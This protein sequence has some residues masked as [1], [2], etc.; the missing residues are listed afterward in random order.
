MTKYDIADAVE[1]ELVKSKTYTWKD[2]GIRIFFES[3]I[4]MFVSFVESL[5]SEETKDSLPDVFKAVAQVGNEMML[6]E[7]FAENAILEA[8]FFDEHRIIT[9][10]EYSLA[11]EYVNRVFSA[12]WKA[13]K[14]YEYHT[15]CV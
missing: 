3:C 6:R 13:Y 14:D 5:R 9:K 12:V 8:P 2:I 15:Y 7:L 1:K 4:T 11:D 10:T